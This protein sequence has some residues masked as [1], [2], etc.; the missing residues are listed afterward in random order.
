MGRWYATFRTQ[1]LNNLRSRCGEAPSSTSL[2]G[3]ALSNGSDNPASGEV[4]LT[5]AKSLFNT[6]SCSAECPFH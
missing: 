4:S 3:E 2:L 1:K 6:N 5:S